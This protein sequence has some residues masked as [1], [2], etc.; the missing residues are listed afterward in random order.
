MRPR[1]PVALVGNPAFA[2][3]HLGWH[4]RK[5]FAEMMGEM[6]AHAQQELSA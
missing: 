1:E 5:P 2:A 4:A 6:V 3:T